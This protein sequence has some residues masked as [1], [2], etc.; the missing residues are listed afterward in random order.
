MPMNEDR[1]KAS[2]RV[3]SQ[4]RGKERIRQILAAALKLLKER[5][6]EEVTTNDIALEARI[7]I[8]SL[9]RYY[10]NRD[11]IIVALTEL[12][13]S[14]ISQI[15]E[16]IGSHPML[17]YL[18]WDEVLILII[19][20]WV[21]YSRL[22]GSFAFLYAGYTNPRLR[23]LSAEHWR[24]FT[25]NFGALLKKRCPQ[26]AEQQITVAF[27]LALSSTEL[28]INETYYQDPHAQP[29]HYEAAEAIG[30]YLFNVCKRHHHDV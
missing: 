29:L 12:Y 1:Y 16:G 20:S 3:P 18:S 30:T 4:E 24:V 27:Q 5:G 10:S 28:G 26:L 25:T 22:N 23:E 11:A 2:R 15:F 19:D 9:Y 8:G 21:N 13:V 14:D 17:R 6:L 7:P